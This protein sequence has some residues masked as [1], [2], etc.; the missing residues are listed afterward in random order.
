MIGGNQRNVRV[1]VTAW[2]LTAT[3]I[4]L[5]AVTAGTARRPVGELPAYREYVRH[6]SA[7]HGG[8]DPS[9]SPV[10]RSWLTVAYT[11]A[12]PLAGWGVRPDVLTAWG[13]LASAAVV[14]IAAAGGRWVLL[15]GGIVVLSGF[16]D[17]LDGTVA[18]LTERVT[19]FGFVLD[20]VVDRLSDVAY[21]LA[22]A[23]L[24]ATASLCV[25]AG[26]ALGLLEYTRARAGNAGMGEIG[27][28][29]L[30]ER[31]VRIAV[32]AGTL[33]SA[34]FWVDQADHLAG[35]GAAAVLVVSG[36]GWGQLLL[37]VRRVLR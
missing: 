31:G 14:A 17:S 30:G 4:G 9:G 24:G 20:S 18:V 37:V 13:L 26:V 8:Y 29:T 16:L 27:V 22:L 2:L 15:A 35:I 33:F 7:L 25:A 32:V 1:V 23:V 19:R 12:R 28:V 21:L 36:V 5:L 10:V 3:T 11:G 6:W 34:G